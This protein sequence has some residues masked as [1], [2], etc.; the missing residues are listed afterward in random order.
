MRKGVGYMEK[1]L[2]GMSGGVDSTVAAY[3]LKAQGYEVIGVTL[4]LV[5]GKEGN[6]GDRARACA[7]ALGIEH[8]TV[9]MKD[10]FKS[11]VIDNFVSEYLNGRTPSPCIECNRHIKFGAM[12]DLAKD[13]GIDKIATGH[14]AKVEKSGDRYILKKADCIEK[15]QSYMLYTLTQEQLSR[16]VFPLQSLTKAQVRDIARKASLPCADAGDSQEICFIEDDDYIRFLTENVSSLP[17]EGD[18]TDKEGNI[19]GTHQGIHRYTIGQR[20]GLG[21]AFGKPMFVVGVDAK[22]NR[23]ILGE[24]GEEYFASLTA[25]RVNFIPFDNFTE[26]MDA[27]CK[28][29][30]GNKIYK[31]RIYPTSPTTVR[32][33]FEDSARAVTPGQSVVFYDGDT[34]LGGGV[35]C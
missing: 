20:K 30:Y 11:C 9:D 8:H 19:L 28:V 14:Y 2:L 23:V 13:W 34:V 15:D 1:I 29:R 6:I 32:V 7:D 35:I 31:G 10:I 5:C 22:S 24:S 21:I 17:P 27:E 25:D 33:E 4:D 16:V 18:F 26:P 3:L 12:M